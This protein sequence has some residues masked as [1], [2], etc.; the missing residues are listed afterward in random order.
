MMEWG[1]SCITIELLEIFSICILHFQW[2]C[3][4]WSYPGHR[5]YIQQYIIFELEHSALNNSKNLVGEGSI[6]IIS[7]NV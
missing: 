6:I 2:Q 7:K 1:W 3:V 4:I 5:H